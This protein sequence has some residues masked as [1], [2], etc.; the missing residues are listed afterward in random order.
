MTLKNAYNIS[1][2]QIEAD[3]E[4]CFVV[5]LMVGYKTQTGQPVYR[6]YRCPFEG[7]E[8]PQ[9]S[10]IDRDREVAVMKALFTVVARARGKADQT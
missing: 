5:K 3:D 9:G 6:I 10:R 1:P 4:F 8:A 7:D 2:D